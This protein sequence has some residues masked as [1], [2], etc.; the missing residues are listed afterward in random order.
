MFFD[1]AWPE[2]IL[3]G[4][5]AL[6]VIGPK[7]L[8]RAMRIAGYW[9]RKARNLSREFQ[10]SVDQMIRE[11][12]LD[13][14]RQELKKASEF[15]IEAEFHKTI[16]PDGSLAESIKPPRIPDFFEEGSPA[17]A[18]ASGAAAL[19][20]PIPAISPELPLA[21]DAPEPDF[22]G[23]EAAVPEPAHEAA[24]LKR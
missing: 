12:E 22:V 24:S 10:N 4:A 3:I 8:P 16:D 21:P 5:V 9:I 11:A 6:V 23:F 2:F 17:A 15:N 14:V 1:I 13:E 20:A 19:P 7:D 18:A